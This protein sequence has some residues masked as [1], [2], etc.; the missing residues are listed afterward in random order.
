MREIYRV[1]HDKLPRF[2]QKLYLHTKVE[3]GK[4]NFSYLSHHVTLTVSFRQTYTWHRGL[5]QSIRLT[6]FFASN[7]QKL[8]FLKDTTLYILG[9]L[10]SAFNGYKMTHYVP[11]K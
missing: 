8:D 3:W 9:S 5:Q 7:D 11:I 1:N 6:T 4:H 10:N 2:I